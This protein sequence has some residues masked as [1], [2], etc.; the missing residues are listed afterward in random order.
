MPTEVAPEYFESQSCFDGIRVERPQN[1]F[2]EPVRA[3]SPF[4]YKESDF[5]ERPQAEKPKKQLRFFKNHT[6]TEA[7]PA[8]EKL[9]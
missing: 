9:T 8:A 4:Q 5:D 7:I 2:F 3:C 6:L 1:M